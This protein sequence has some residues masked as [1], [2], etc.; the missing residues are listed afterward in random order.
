MRRAPLSPTL[1]VWLMTTRGFLAQSVTSH[2]QG[3]LVTVRLLE[4][5]SRRCKAGPIIFMV[6]SHKDTKIVLVFLKSRAP[7]CTAAPGDSH[8]VS[9]RSDAASSLKREVC[10][11]AVEARAYSLVT[12]HPCARPLGSLDKVDVPQRETAAYM[13]HEHV[14]I[15]RRIS[16]KDSKSSN[17]SSPCI[18]KAKHYH[19]QGDNPSAR[20]QENPRPN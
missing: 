3:V 1:T 19:E 16:T 11:P 6:S 2:T 10:M 13:R 8:I 5:G 12:Y 4:D 14:F 20:N 9:D 17:P 18:L 15:E 7:T